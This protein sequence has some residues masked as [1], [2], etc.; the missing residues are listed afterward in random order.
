MGRRLMIIFERQLQHFILLALL[1]GDLDAQISGIN[2]LN[3]RG[4]IRLK[5]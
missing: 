1:L 3:H 4:N 2:N 5:C